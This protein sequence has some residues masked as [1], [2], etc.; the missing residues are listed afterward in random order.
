MRHRIKGRKLGRN[1]SHRRAM[2]RNMACS[3][4]RSL[5]VDEDAPERPKVPGRIITTV[6]KAK[7]LRPFIE[8]LITMGRKAAQ[9][10]NAAAELKTDAEPNSDAW[11]DWRNSEKWNQWNQ[12]VAPAVSLRRKAFGLLRD[13]EA[14]D[15]LFSELADR[16]ADRNGGYTRV[17]RLA[18]VRLGD[19][20]AQA[21]FEFCGERDRVR[22][23]SE[24][25][26]PTVAAEPESSEAEDSESEPTGGVEDDAVAET[27][28]ESSADEA[29]EDAV[30]EEK[31][32]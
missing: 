3:L 19:A 32:S 1:A 2:F 8:R 5:R 23:K 21:L 27:T 14:V 9:I 4:I 17:V 16:F 30:G 13:H 7:E 12:A 15:I 31:D 24:R 26:V 20:G 6:P 25:V 29:S 28:T 22:K 10:E 11:R 18:S